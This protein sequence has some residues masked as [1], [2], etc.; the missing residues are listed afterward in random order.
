[1]FE[2]EEKHLEMCIH[3]LNKHEKTEEEVSNINRKSQYEKKIERNE[4]TGSVWR[5]IEY[6]LVRVIKSEGKVAQR[7][8]FIKFPTEN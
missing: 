3:L 4:H 1:M 5:F 8:A 6:M 7:A 2:K